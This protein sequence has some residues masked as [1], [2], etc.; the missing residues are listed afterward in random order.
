MSGR[1]LA[2]MTNGEEGGAA[3]DKAWPEREFKSMW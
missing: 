1:I 2:E 3:Y